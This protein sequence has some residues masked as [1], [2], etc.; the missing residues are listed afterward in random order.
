VRKRKILSKDVF[1]IYTIKKNK[2]AY[3]ICINTYENK[4]KK[5]KNESIILNFETFVNENKL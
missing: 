2:Q 5:K 4:D 3:A 1:L